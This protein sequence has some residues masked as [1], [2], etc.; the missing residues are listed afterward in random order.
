M[1]E[2][3]IIGTQPPCPRCKLITQ[4]FKD[5]I[6]EL[7]LNANIKH[8]GFNEPDAIEYAK[9]LGLQTGTASIVANK[10]NIE[11]EHKKINPDEKSIYNFEYDDYLYTGWSYELDEHLRFFEN[12]ALEVGILMTPSI[13]INKKLKHAGSVPRISLINQWLLELK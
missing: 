2:I 6:A 7:N 11:I 10:L 5:K 4:V 1:N 13:I 12:K 9:T 3:L 8:I